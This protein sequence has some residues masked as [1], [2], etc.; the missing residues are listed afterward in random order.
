MAQH[1]NSQATTSCGPSSRF[2]APHSSVDIEAVKKFQ[3]SKKTQANTS[4]A[5][6]IWREWVAYC[7]KNKLTMEKCSYNLNGE[8]TKV[9]TP[10]TCFWIQRFV[11]EVRRGAKA[12]WFRGCPTRYSQTWFRSCGARECEAF[13]QEVLISTVPGMKFGN[14]SK[15]T[16]NFNYQQCL[17]SVYHRLVRWL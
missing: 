10:A 4:W 9:D 17:S 7:L 14:A 1:F 5:S 13:S 15:F 3:V 6:N 11:L 12:M 8:I 16:I 2:A